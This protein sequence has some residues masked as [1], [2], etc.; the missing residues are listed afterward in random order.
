MA[1]TYK[2]PLKTIKVKVHGVTDPITVA[3][4][5]SA[6]NAT[7]AIAEFDKGWKMHLVGQNKTTV[8][9]YHAVEYVEVTTALSD[10]ITKADPYCPEDESE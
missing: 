4:T 3:D 1:N 2:K 5:V 7:A 10:S 6:P 8:V 9:P